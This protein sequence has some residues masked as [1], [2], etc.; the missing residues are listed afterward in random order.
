[1]SK[2]KVPMLMA[3][4]REE[5]EQKALREKYGV[6]ENI[7]VVEKKSTVAQVVRVLLRAIGSLARL[8]ANILL[9]VLAV[10]GLATLIYPEMRQAGLSVFQQIGDQLTAYFS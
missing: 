1:M 5:R 8:A 7:K 2:R 3:E 10:I 9:V 6:T 4:L